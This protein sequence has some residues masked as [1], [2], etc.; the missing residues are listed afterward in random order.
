M[1]NLK[2]KY[3][4]FFIIFFGC[5]KLNI[6]IELKGTYQNDDIELT[7]NDGDINGR[8]KCNFLYGCYVIENDNITISIGGTKVFCENEFN[9][10]KLRDV[11]KFEI[12]GNKLI[13][14]GENL[15]L[16]LYKIN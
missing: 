10:Q 12:I 2:L 14:K 11:E 16:I 13:L 3:S 8:T 1:Q 5:E 4:I 9:I 6:N 15:E 7:F